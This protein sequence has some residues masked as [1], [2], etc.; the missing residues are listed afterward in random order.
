MWAKYS[1]ALQASKFRGCFAA[2]LRPFETESRQGAMYYVPDQRASIRTD[3]V[4]D[5][6]QADFEH[7]VLFAP[8]ELAN[9]VVPSSASLAADAGV[10]P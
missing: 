3:P 4:I 7:D 9:I 6:P 2:N 1:N 5:P 10:K 8:Y